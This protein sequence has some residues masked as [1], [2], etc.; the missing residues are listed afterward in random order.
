LGDLAKY[1]GSPLEESLS[2]PPGL[3]EETLADASEAVVREWGQRL[4]EMI[5]KLIEEPAYRLAGAEEAIRQVMSAVEQLLQHHE[6][7][8]KE[9]GER[10]QN[11]FSRFHQLL[12]GLNRDIHS[13][14]KTAAVVAEFRQ[15]LAGYPKLR[16]QFLILRQMAR[17]YISLR[18]NLS[19]ELREVGFCRAR[20]GD[21]LKAYSGQP[22]S[23]KG[24]GAA[25]ERAQIP[26]RY[27]FPNGCPDLSE[28]VEQ[29]LGQITPEQVEE[30]H[31]RVQEMIHKQFMALIQVCL[32]PSNLIKNLEGVMQKEVEAFLTSCSAGHNVAELLLEQ[33]PAEEDAVNEI[34]TGFDE[35]VPELAG[36][37]VEKSSEMCFLSVPTGKAGERI[38]ELADR[39][40]PNA[41]SFPGP[42]GEEIILYRE[43]PNLDP[44]RLEQFGPHCREAYRQ[45]LQVEHYS[46]HARNDVAF[47]DA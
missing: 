25:P 1:L 3:V 20:L 4:T 32:G 2:S 22:A 14:G 37:H 19:D 39:I 38:V 18:G 45:M 46:P 13:R 17:G 5:V 8:C 40:V 21:L 34:S 29:L 47:G 7:L 16:Y 44:A 43:W 30:L 11:T 33:Y 42:T 36:I 24:E 6:P 35:A 15:L 27:L 28:A 12:D 23:D 9:I 10:A 41:A 26:G 31:G